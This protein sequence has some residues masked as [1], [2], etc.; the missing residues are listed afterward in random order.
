MI[1]ATTHCVTSS[2]FTVVVR[3]AQG[4]QVVL[5]AR[6]AGTGLS[7]NNVTVAQLGKGKFQQA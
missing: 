2:S 7:G 4:R 3:S 5:K 1:P 6:R